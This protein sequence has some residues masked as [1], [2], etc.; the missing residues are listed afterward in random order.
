M[1]TNRWDQDRFGIECS[2]AYD[3]H[4]HPFPL[5]TS[6]LILI[7][8]LMGETVCI[9]LSILSDILGT[10]VGGCVEDFGGRLWF[11]NL[12]GDMYKRSPTKIP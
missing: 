6:Q 8:L 5:L 7:S 9:S 3:A 12:V 11:D 2:A 1:Q 4:L 10:V